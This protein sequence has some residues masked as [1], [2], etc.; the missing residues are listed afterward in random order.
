VTIKSRVVAAFAVVAL[1]AASSAFARGFVQDS[2]LF[3]KIKPG[4]TAQEVEKI[5]GAP[6]NRSSFPRLGLTSMDY[7]TSIWG[8]TYDVGVMLGPDG[9]VREVQKLQRHRGIP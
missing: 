4:A 1:L 8:D 5:L 3:D 2:S 6:G 7:V 9:R